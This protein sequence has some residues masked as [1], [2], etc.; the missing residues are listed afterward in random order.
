VGGLQASDKSNPLLRMDEFGGKLVTFFRGVPVKSCD[1]LLN[2]EAR[3]I[4]KRHADCFF[5]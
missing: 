2:A 5:P 3:T 4:P 1:A